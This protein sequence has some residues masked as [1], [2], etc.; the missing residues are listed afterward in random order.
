VPGLAKL[1][2]AN[3]HCSRATPER[4]EQLAASAAGAIKPVEA[5]AAVKRSVLKF[6]LVVFV[7]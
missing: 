5:T 3:W 4:C 1:R 6:M 2:G 7:Y